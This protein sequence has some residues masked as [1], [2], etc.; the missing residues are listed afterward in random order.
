M[1]GAPIPVGA[2]TVLPKEAAVVKNHFLVMDSIVPQGRHIRKKG[3]EV[4]KGVRVLRRYSVIHPGTLAVL[5]S[6]GMSGVKVFR[7]PRVSVIA[8]GSELV[9]PGSPL[10]PGKIY[11][12]NSWMIAACLRDMGIDTVLKKTVR[13]EPKLIRRVV[14]KALRLSDVVILLGG[15]SVG[16]YDYVKDILKKLDVKTIFW[17]VKQKPGKPLYFGKRKDTLVFGLPGNPASAYICFYEYVY[18]ALRL[19]SGFQSPDLRRE[20]A[21]IESKIKRDPEKSIFLKGKIHQNHKMSTVLALPHQGSHMV[22]SL[23]ESNGL[24]VLPPGTGQINRGQA[25]FV[26]RLPHSKVDRS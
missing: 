2:D 25:V 21:R 10:H 14:Q 11:D 18:S 20:Q 9:E 16:D 3:E 7:K 23:H 13:D 15:V 19:M 26:D 6:L 4:K 22:S 5:T 8:T 24:I 17:K 1:T 12:S